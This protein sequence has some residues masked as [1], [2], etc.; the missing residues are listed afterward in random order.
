MMNGLK[1]VFKD[2]GQGDTIIIEHTNG[3]ERWIGVIDCNEYGRNPVIDYVKSNRSFQSISF[4]VISHLHVDHISGISDL[5]EYC[6]KN[7]ITIEKLIHTINRS[8]L[9]ILDKVETRSMHEHGVLWRLIDVL[10]EGIKNKTITNNFEA[11]SNMNEINLAGEIILKC[12]APAG[13]NL[14]ELLKGIKRKRDKK[15]IRQNL[16]MYATILEIKKNGKSILLTSDADK[17]Y[18]NK[19]EN[20]INNSVVIAQAPHHGSFRNIHK[21]FWECIKIDKQQIIVFSVGEDNRYALPDT[22][23]VSFFNEKGYEIRATNY[24]NGLKQLSNGSEEAIEEYEGKED[25]LMDILSFI[26]EL[27]KDKVKSNN[28]GRFSGDLIFEIND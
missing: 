3:E 12:H 15:R 26:A 18:F 6:T 11:S 24:V 16:N 27:P 8:V 14:G 5:I 20:S 2:V 13:N 10:D 17:R 21:N 19:L 7:G 28:Y 9:D 1:V 4:I 25:S 22:E 23:T